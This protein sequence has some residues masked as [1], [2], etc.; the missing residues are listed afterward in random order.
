MRVWLWFRSSLLEPAAPLKRT[1]EPPHSDLAAHQCGRSEA[2]ITAAAV[3]SCGLLNE[4]HTEIINSSVLRFRSSQTD[5]AHNRANFGIGTLDMLVD[6][7]AADDG[8][9]HAA[10]EPRLV[11]RRVLAKRF[12]IGGIE[13]PWCVGVDHDDVGGCAR[14]QGTA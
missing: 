1:S 9:H 7:P 12:Q 11:E 3:S 10:G 8:A 13:H 2:R 5:S 6:G 14:T 4:S